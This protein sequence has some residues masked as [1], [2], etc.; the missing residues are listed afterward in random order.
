MREN[1]QRVIDRIWSELDTLSND[2]VAVVIT[3]LATQWLGNEA[4]DALRKSRPKWTQPTRTPKEP[5]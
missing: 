2:D 1:R 3:F 5:T 4:G